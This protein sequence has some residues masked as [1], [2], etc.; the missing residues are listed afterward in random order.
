MTIIRV[1][2]NIWKSYPPHFGYAMSIARSPKDRLRALRAGRVSQLL[3]PTPADGLPPTDPPRITL[4]GKPVAT[5]G[6]FDAVLERAHAAQ[7]SA[8]IAEPEVK[9]ESKEPKHNSYSAG[10]SI[11]PTQIAA[12]IV[13][14]IWQSKLGFEVAK[15]GVPLSFG[16]GLAADMALRKN[17]GFLDRESI[18]P[19][20]LPILDEARTEQLPTDDGSIHPSSD[21][22]PFES[23]NGPNSHPNSGATFGIQLSDG[24][25]LLPLFFPRG[26]EGTKK[27]NDYVI[28][29]IKRRLDQ[30]F[31]QHN[32]DAETEHTHGG[33]DPDKT[34]HYVQSPYESSTR[35]SGRTDGTVTIQIRNEAWRFDMQTFD[36]LAD[37]TPT[38]REDTAYTN[39]K[40]NLSLLDE[41]NQGNIDAPDAM[42]RYLA[43]GD[44]AR[45]LTFEM[46]TKGRREIPWDEWKEIV[47]KQLDKLFEDCRPI[48]RWIVK[49]DTPAPKQTSPED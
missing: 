18:D 32:I 19:W 11:S 29:E 1:K 22:N 44:Y 12:N 8:A 21:T 46:F 36:Q 10:R 14:S 5:S 33:S 47:D 25:E 3:E 48:E 42:Q 38:G 27:K 41:F 37:G 13:T 49:P 23:A 6:A 30:C 39:I 20:S 16:V 9:P 7:L 40:Q 43:R 2:R 31:E 15:Y 28:G 17:L 35:G 4:N 34:E 26:S 24:N 45:S